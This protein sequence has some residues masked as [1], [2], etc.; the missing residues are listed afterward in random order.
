MA[1]RGIWV[2]VG[3]VLW[4][5]SGCAEGGVFNG[6]IKAVDAS[7]GT[8]TVKSSSGQ[9]QTFRVPATATVTLDGKMR[10]LG[11][12]SVGDRIT[13][14][15]DEANRVT[16]VV[17]RT[18]TQPSTPA[19]RTEPP[20][21]TSGPSGSRRPVPTDLAAAPWPQFRGPNRDG[22]SLETGLLDRWPA[23]GPQL[24]WTATGLGAGYSSVAVADGLVLTMG[25]QGNEECLLAMDLR[26]GRPR[27]KAACGPAFR[28]SRGDGPRCT[29]TVD[30][31]RVY[32]LGANGGLICAELRTGRII[33]QKDL[34]REFDAR[35]ITWGISESVLVDGDRLICTPGGRQATMVALNKHNGSVVW[36]VHVPE[37]GAAGYASAIP[38]TVGGVRQYVQFTSRAVIGVRAEDGQF[39]WSDSSS[40]NSTANCSMPVVYGDHVF[41]A[42]GYGTGG[43]LL[44]LQSQGNQTTATRVYE[45]KDMKNHHGGMIVLDGYL[46]GSNDPGILTCIELLTG[47]VVWTDRSV[48]KASLTYADGHLYVR[49]E[50]GPVALVEATPEGYREKGRFR[51]PQRSDKNSWAYP[52]VADGKLFL[53]DMDVL[54]VYD[55]RAR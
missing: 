4:V 40:A 48:G 25:N 51:Q 35:N 44:R 14:F 11:D 34:L 3:V 8:I 9:T 17:S 10:G 1:L 46:Y 52:V 13:V 38:L 50:Q 37:A 30:G 53:R 54:L 24:A 49:S 32:A 5:A 18:G 21:D 19:P 23:D 16:R 22:I 41:T 7:G 26:D 28:E 20:S 6:L 29:P 45:T 15:T 12:L 33:W 2:A 43:T 42:S 31:D 27:W 36:R 47:R 39:L 55:I